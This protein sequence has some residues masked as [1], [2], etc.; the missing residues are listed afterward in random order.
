MIVIP[1]CPGLLVIAVNKFPFQLTIPLRADDLLSRR[2]EKLRVTVELIISMP[3]VQV[4]NDRYTIM[5]DAVMFIIRQAITPVQ[6]LIYGQ[7]MRQRFG[8]ESGLRGQI[9]LYCSVTASYRVLAPILEAYRRAYSSVEIMMHTG[10]QADGLSRVLSG[11]DDISVSGRPTQLPARVDFLPLQQSPLRFCAPRGDCSV[12]DLLLAGDT[13]SEDFDWSAIPFIVPE[14]GITKDLLTD[15]FRSRSIRPNIYAQVAGHEAI[16]AMVGLGLG[17]GVA[18]EL[19]VDA[20]GM[21]DKV[22]FLPVATELA[23]KGSR[24]RFG[25]SGS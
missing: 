17:I 16:V 10:D 6:V 11:Q 20:S 19:V 13:E 23:P 1:E 18:P 7:Q 8:G 21:S 22:G 15:W 2:K 12:R 4:R 24:A 14:R 9:S 3:T 25:L 5:L